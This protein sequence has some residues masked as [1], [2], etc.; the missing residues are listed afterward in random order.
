MPTKKEFDALQAELEKEKLK[1]DALLR[2]VY[3]VL[4][5]LDARTSQIR[6][7][8]GEMKPNEIVMLLREAADIIITEQ[9]LKNTGDREA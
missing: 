5:V 1:T 2:P 3:A 9:A 4:V 7:D 6:I 8:A